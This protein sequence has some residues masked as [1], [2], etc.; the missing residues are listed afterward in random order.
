[1]EI[2]PT[3]ALL[4]VI[5]LV[6]LAYGVKSALVAA[7]ALI[8]FGAA[9]ALVLHAIG[10]LNVMAVTLAMAIVC[11]AVLLPAG[12]RRSGP[13][14]PKPDPAAALFA[15]IFAYGLVSAIA[16]PWLFRGETLVISYD[17]SA[18]GVPISLLFPGTVLTPLAFSSGNLS[19]TA[20]LGVTAV[21]L[22]VATVLG[23]R[24]GPQL[25][26][27]AVIAA[28]AVNAV[29]G[30]MDLVGL[31]EVVR[32]FHTAN[33]ALLFGQTIA[34]VERVI[35][36]FPEAS[37]F[38]G[39]SSVAFA[40]AASRYLDSGRRVWGA[41]AATNGLLT[42]VALSSTGLAAFGVALVVLASRFF[43]TLAI[44]VSS[45]PALL[46]GFLFTF[47]GAAFVFFLLLLTPLGSVAWS[48]VDELIFNKPDSLSAAERGAWAQQGLRIG[49]DTFGLG[50]GLGSTRANGL[51]SVWFGNI[52]APGLLLLAIFLGR[53]LIA[54]R[55][56]FA[57]ASERSMFRAGFV[58]IVTDLSG[59]VISGTVVDPGTLFVLLAGLMVSTKTRPDAPSGHRASAP[60]RRAAARAGPGSR[61]PA[62][63][64]S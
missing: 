61:P 60:R 25:L 48:V 50:A 45:G 62:M 1:M 42:L 58:A 46:R 64:L 28:A 47:G 31:Q 5:V 56:S 17:R 55:S 24:Y 32:I 16:C 41:L 18:V 13:A 30:T 6:A 37:A 51:V 26:E 23:R 44:G 43:L 20:Y 15:L 52:G 34:G 22:Y 59:K 40:Y 33:Y 8:P 11:V 39:M 3:G 21:I 9:A 53:L 63:P 35:G 10:G 27:R 57:G 29:L 19:Q 7:A 2:P 49:L 14:L 4:V 38:G 54:K 12:L 36:G